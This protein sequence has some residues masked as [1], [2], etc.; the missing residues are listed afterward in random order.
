MNELLDMYQQTFEEPFPLMLVIG[1]PDEDLIELIED[2]LVS[3][4]KYD[5]STPAD[6]DI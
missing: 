6:V 1:M 2:C 3:K 4:K 5:P